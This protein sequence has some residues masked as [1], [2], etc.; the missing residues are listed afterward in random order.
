MNAKIKST[1]DQINEKLKVIEEHMCWLIKPDARFRVGQR[2]EWSRRGRERG[3]ARGKLAQKGTVKAIDGFGIVVKLDGRKHPKRYH[4]AF[5]NS[6][7]GKKL[8]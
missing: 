2:V 7:N 8:F 3:F 5:F 6:V 1:I 4:H